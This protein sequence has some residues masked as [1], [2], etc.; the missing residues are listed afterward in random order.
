MYE[1]EKREVENSGGWV[2][3]LNYGYI[4]VFLK[5]NE[6][7]VKISVD[8]AIVRVDWYDVLNENAPVIDELNNRLLE[9]LGEEVK[10]S[11]EPCY[12]LNL[13]DEFEKRYL[14][15]WDIHYKI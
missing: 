8:H 13:G 5:N 10:Y 3:S 7:R 1:A 4:D 12:K 2:S 14:S 11:K 6:M 9:V 15:N